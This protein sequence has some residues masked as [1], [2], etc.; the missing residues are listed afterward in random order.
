MCSS[1]FSPALGARPSTKS[2]TLL[3]ERHCMTIQRPHELRK[4]EIL[5][6]GHDKVKA[7]SRMVPGPLTASFVG[8]A[9][10]AALRETDLEAALTSVWERARAPWP[11]VEL[12]ATAYIAH[13]GRRLGDA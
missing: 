7:G 12:E 6:P 1:T 2:R 8:A 10:S 11:E 3:S 9:R 5:R 13:V 4:P